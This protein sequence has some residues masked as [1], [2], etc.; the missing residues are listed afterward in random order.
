MAS[1]EMRTRGDGKSR[2]EDEVCGWGDGCRAGERI[3]LMTGTMTYLAVLAVLDARRREI[4]SWILL[5]GSLGALL[6]AGVFLVRGMVS[7]DQ[8]LF[9]AVP[10][11][12]LLALAQTTHSAGAG[13]G[14]VLLQVSIFLLLERT[15]VAFGISMIVMGGFCAVLLLLKKG[16]RDMRI[17]YLPFLWLGCLVAICTCE[18]G[19]G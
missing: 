16:S 9:G 18:G 13:D 11:V 2:N 14:I 19:I 12:I 10:G 1:R 8:L 15:I 5:L 4:E 7:W 17:P 3:M 6:A